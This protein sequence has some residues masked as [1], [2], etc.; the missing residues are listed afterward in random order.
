MNAQEDDQKTNNEESKRKQEIKLKLTH[1][2]T[3]NAYKRKSKNLLK[4]FS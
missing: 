3:I 1:K 4:T 2:K